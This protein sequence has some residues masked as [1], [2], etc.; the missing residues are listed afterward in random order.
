MR[1][2][3]LPKTA[4]ITSLVAAL[5]LISACDSGSNE[6][7]QQDTP[8]VAQSNSEAG[9]SQ[10][11]TDTAPAPDQTASSTPSDSSAESAAGTESGT[12]A[13]TTTDSTASSSDAAQVA[14]AGDPKVLIKRYNCV[15]CH[16]T[17]RKLLGPAYREVAAK[18][19][20]E[21]GAADTL[22]AK[23]KEG[24]SGVWGA[25]PMPPNPGVPDGDVRLIVDWILAGAN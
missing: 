19:R 23:V 21:D 22:V 10:G 16:A 12:T 9:P 17:D 24:G 25:I 2:E 15:S 13:D 6:T 14:A 3:I 7:A 4:T 18:Y 20:D 8:A 11:R 1:P 5:F